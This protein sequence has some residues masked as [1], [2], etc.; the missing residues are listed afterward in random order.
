MDRTTSEQLKYFWTKSGMRQIDA[1]QY[2]GISQSAISQ[3]LK[4]TI[5][6]N[7]DI[8]LQFAEML[9]IN[10]QQIDPDIF[11]PKQRKS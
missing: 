10:P 8:I 9:G 4:G 5:K 3:Y 1:A 11:T 6:L 7:T 2:L